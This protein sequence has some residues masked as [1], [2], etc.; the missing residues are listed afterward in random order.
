MDGLISFGTIITW[1]NLHYV[2]L[3]E[4]GQITY[5]ARIIEDEALKNSLMQRFDGLEKA[6]IAGKINAQAK[7]TNTLYCFVVLSTTDFE[8]DVVLL[9]N[10]KLGNDTANVEKISSYCELNENDA[11]ELKK[12]IIENNGIARELQ[13]YVRNLQ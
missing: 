10:N 7:L 2:Y 4:I 12:Q 5:L 13:D 8:G 6:S 11:V 9:Y 3:S 1:N